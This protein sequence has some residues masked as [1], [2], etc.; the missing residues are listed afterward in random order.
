MYYAHSTFNKS[1]QDW[2]LLNSHLHEV[3]KQAA[4]FAEEFNARSMGFTSGL[5]H[6]I[7]KYS[8]EF[9]A[10]LRGENL[11]TVDHSTAGALALQDVCKPHIAKLLAYTVAGHHTGLQNYGNV[12]TGLASRLFSKSLPDY[13]AY[14]TD[15]NTDIEENHAVNLHF[16][17][18]HSGFS[19][20][21]Y[22]RMLYSCLVDAD[23]LDTEKFYS[24]KKALLRNY[25]TSIS[26]LYDKLCVHMQ[27]KLKKVDNSSLNT[28]RSSV[29]FDC[30]KAADLPNKM[31]SLT[32]PTGGGKTLSSMAFAL[33]HAKKNNMRRVIYVIPY[34]SIIE[35]TADVF[36]SI[37]GY[38]NVLEHHS[39]YDFSR[40]MLNDAAISSVQLASENWDLPI[41]VTTNIQFFESLFA[42][43]PSKCRKL[44]N[45]AN[46]VII[47]DEVQM[48]PT[49]Y[50]KPSTAA[51]SELVRN[52]GCSVV[53]CTATQPSLNK[54]TTHGLDIKE[55]VGNPAG[56]YTS[57]KRV[58]VTYSG[59]V[60]VDDLLQRLNKEESYLCIVNTRSLASVLYR[61]IG[62]IS[63]NYHLS[64]RMCPAHRREKLNEIKRRLLAGLP[65][66]IISTQLIEAGVDIDLPVVFRELSG[67][68]SICQAAGRCNREGKQTIGNVHEQQHGQ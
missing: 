43:K 10:K 40:N 27:E 68:D 17:N 23:Y 42:N 63:G 30:L 9:Q 50:I 2:H 56:L 7:G 12:E 45:L 20:S 13:S 49:G 61:K 29:Y 41:V 51:L 1:Q 36:R 65:C 60:T 46:S 66:K 26:D 11:Q 44:H 24:E 31:F 37:F 21:F 39:N 67:I 58:K 4:D 22:T 35:Q 53:L 64:A 19:A 52:Y 47:L 57:L 48:L 3:A 54:F 25:T 6:D 15:I 28:L 33:A 14:K 55:I 8:K 34:T 62:S 5:Y 59:E 38:N 16:D 18:S 32:V